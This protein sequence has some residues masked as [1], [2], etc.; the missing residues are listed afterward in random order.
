LVK[1]EVEFRRQER[2][3]RK[4]GQISSNEFVKPLYLWLFI[5][6]Q[7]SDCSILPVDL[8][9]FSSMQIAHEIAEMSRASATGKGQLHQ[10]MQIF[11]GSGH[12]NHIEELLVLER[13]RL[14]ERI[15]NKGRGGRVQALSFGQVCHVI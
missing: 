5:E 10:S 7:I 13:D 15:H 1:E 8:I 6:L 12:E 3:I 11:E 14:L 9:L 2:S 4:Q